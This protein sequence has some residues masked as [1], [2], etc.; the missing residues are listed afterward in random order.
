M[1]WVTVTGT[2]KRKSEDKPVVLL[3]EPTI[4]T[5]KAGLPAAI[6]VGKALAAAGLTHGRERVPVTCS[7]G[8]GGV[9]WLKV[10]SY[11]GT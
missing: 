9:Y 3:A 5:G 8:D 4:S 2:A 11:P 1:T 6:V 7:E 10:G